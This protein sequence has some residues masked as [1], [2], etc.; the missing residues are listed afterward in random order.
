M[1]KTGTPRSIW[2]TASPLC[3]TWAATWRMCWSGAAGKLAD[4]LV[5]EGDP[6][7]DFKAMS[8]VRL[9][10]RDGHWLDPTRLL[11]QAAKYARTAEPPAR[12]RFDAT[13]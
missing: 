4:L 13:Y 12:P 5:V 1:Q 7:L 9:V 11:A 3:A 10:A 6:L 2:R 8:L